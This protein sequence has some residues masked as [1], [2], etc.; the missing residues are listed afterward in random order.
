[1][2]RLQSVLA[3]TTL[4]AA[5][6]VSLS[7]CVGFAPEPVYYQ[8]PVAYYSYQPDYYYAPRPAYSAFFFS[9][10]GNHRSHNHRGYGG[11]HHR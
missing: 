8:A 2:N 7:A 11:H 3:K 9:Y 1:M 4:L 5:A 10:Q 6:A